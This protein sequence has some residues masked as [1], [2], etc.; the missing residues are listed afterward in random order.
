[1]KKITL[2]DAERFVHAGYQYVEG[3][4][5]CGSLAVLVQRELFDRDVTV[6]PAS[7]RSAGRLG[8]RRDILRIQPETSYAVETPETGD[9]VLYWNTEGSEKR[10]HVGTVFLRDGEVWVLH[11]VDEERGVM[12][13]RDADLRG[14]GLV[15]D[16]FYRWKT[17]TYAL[18]LGKH[19]LLAQPTET[20]YVSA[21]RTLAETLA[22][23]G[24]TGTGWVVTIEG[25]EVPPAMW[26]RTRVKE[27][28]R[29]LARSVAR[30]QVL[31]LV[32]MLVLT[33]FTFGIAGYGGA[34]AGAFGGGFA[35]FAAAAVVFVGGSI[36]INKFLGPKMGSMD[37]GGENVPPTYSLS[38]GRNAGRQWQ[39][40]SLVLGQTKA[41]PD[42]A[43]QPYTWME[44]DDQYL[45][46]TLHAGI[47]CGSVADLRN[48][49]TL[50]STYESVTVRRYGFP[51]GDSD[52]LP[53]LPTSV[54]TVPGGQLD[55]PNN[56]PGPYRY[57]T[58][59]ITTVRLEIDIQ[60]TLSALSSKGKQQTAV[61][62]I[63]IAY[64]PVG[65]NT[66]LPFNEGSIT[67]SNL[68]QKP[69]RR[70]FA[71]DVPEGQYQIRVRKLTPD[72][73]DDNLKNH[74]LEWTVLRSFQP[75][76]AD[77]G[78]QPRVELKIKATGQISGALD[79][80]NWIA[81]A[82]P[83]PIWD[84]SSW[85]TATTP[86]A[87]GLSNPGAQI[88]RLLR[89]IYRSS[90]G[91]LIAGAGLPDRRIDIESLKAFMV[92]C[93]TMGFRYDAM[94]QEALSLNDLLQSIAYAGLGTMSDHSGRIGVVYAAESQ[95]TEGVVNMVAMKAKSFEITYTLA[96]TADEYQLEFFDR[97]SDW[98]W[99]S[100]R[101]RAPGVTTP[102]FSSS[103]N[104]RGVTTRDHAAVLARFSQG[105][106]LYGRKTISWDMDLEHVRYRRGAIVAL[107][108]DLTQW[109]YGGACRAITPGIGSFTVVV[110]EPIPTEVTAVRT[111][112]LNVPG[113]ASMRVFPV[114][115]VSSNGRVITVGQAWPAS[116]ALPGTDGLAAHDYRWIYDIKASPGYRVRILSIEPDSDLKGAR[117]T[118]TPDSPEFWNYVINGEYIPPPN[119]SLLTREQ[120]VVSNLQVERTRV[121]VGDAWEHR[122]NATWDVRGQYSSAQVWSAVLGA[123]LE[124]VEGGSV[125][126]GTSLSWRVPPDQAWIIE[127]RPFDE[128]GRPGVKAVFT[129]V[130]PS[131]TVGAVQNLTVFPDSTGMMAMWKAPEADWI[132]TKLRLGV[133]WEL[134]QQV[135]NG[136]ADRYNLG[137]LP[138]DDHIL[139]A[140]HVNTADDESPPVGFPFTVLAPLQPIITASPE[141]NEAR[142]TWTECRTTQPLRAYEVRIGDLYAEALLVATTTAPG[143]VHTPPRAGTHM[144]WVTAIDVAE[145]AGPPGYIAIT[146][147]PGITEGI[148]E[149]QQGLEDAYAGIIANKADIDAINAQ[150]ADITGAPEWDV[151]DTYA[152]DQIVKHSGG[153]YRSKIDGNIG[154]E[155]SGATDEFWEKI[156]D[157]DSIGEAVAAHAIQL[158]DHETRIVNNEGELEAQSSRI[159][160]IA[161]SVTSSGA[162]GII[163][164]PELAQG[165]N[166]WA[167]TTGLVAYAADAAGVPAGS[168]AAQLVSAAAQTSG[169]R[170]NGRLL[171]GAVNTAGDVVRVTPGERI[172][173]A[174]WVRLT[175][176]AAGGTSLVAR[177]GTTDNPT[178]QVVLAT[179]AG[180]GWQQLT[181]TFV[182][183]AGASFVRLGMR[184]S[185]TGAE[186][187]AWY[188][189]MQAI[190]RGA[191]TVAVNAAVEEATSALASSIQAEA[192][193]RQTVVANITSAS[194]NNLITNPTFDPAGWRDAGGGGMAVDYFA[195][196]AAGVPAAAPSARVMRLTKTAAAAAWSGREL[197]FGTGAATLAE[198]RPN[199]VVDFSVSVWAPNGTPANSVLLQVFAVDAANAVIAGSPVYRFYVPATGGWQVLSGALT[200]PAGAVAFAGHFVL[201]ESAP[202]S[203]VMWVAEPDVRKRSASALNLGAS[204]QATSTALAT[205]DGKVAASYTLTV[206]AGNRVAGFRAG[207]DGVTSDFVVLADKFAWS[208]ESLGQV[209]YGLVLGLINGV[210]SFGFSG[211]M[212]LDGVLQ[213]RMIGADQI[214]AVHIRTDEI[215][216]R[217]LKAG[218]VLAD[219]LGVGVSGNMLPN[220]KLVTT[221]GWSA[222]PSAGVLAMLNPTNYLGTAYNPQGENILT[223]YEPASTGAQGTN[224]WSY[225]IS[226]WVG[227]EALQRYG[228]SAYV[229]SHRAVCQIYIEFVDNGGQ[230]VGSSDP[231]NGQGTNDEQGGGGKYLTWFKRIYGFA[232]APAN[233]ASARLILRKSGNKYGNADSWLMATL[234]FLGRATPYQVL[235][236]DYSPS[237]VGTLID[238]SG[239]R[240]TSLGAISPDMGLVVKGRLVSNSAVPGSMTVDLD[241][242]SISMSRNGRRVEINPG[243]F[244]F[245]PEGYWDPKLFY[246]TASD[247]MVL[248]GTF[249]ADSINAVNTLNIAGQAVTTMRNRRGGN[250]GPIY[251]G[252]VFGN[253][254][255]L[256]TESAELKSGGNGVI[257]FVEYES[258]MTAGFVQSPG[259]RIVNLNT[260]VIVRAWHHSGYDSAGYPAP[261]DALQPLPPGQVLTFVDYSPIIG[262]NNYAFQTVH[263]KTW[264]THS[265]Y[266]LNILASHR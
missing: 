33:Y 60:G 95:P 69:V 107:S 104:V 112:G 155:P 116:A 220:S 49:N 139:W 256:M 36:L 85:Q 149:L 8:Q 165:V 238:A 163:A 119:N 215:E 249:T 93:T 71:Q 161:A 246:D 63:E 178:T 12:L 192:T 255:T 159:D 132:A 176:A 198:G 50:L 89:G 148:E 201:N 216:A 223:L 229:G 182:A 239:I 51:T 96:T 257:L 263:Y 25:R 18:E 214:R 124:L 22:E 15:R 227:V 187:L 209:K 193:A 98:S 141:I 123:P 156:G 179:Y 118:A 59:S 68:G 169:E 24:V 204:V 102:Q 16:A 235:P 80:I 157:Y 262:T 264:V 87:A 75:D 79:E 251:G 42:L 1:M 245:G 244:W 26:S 21:G 145:N 219:K 173:V 232:T 55:A 138:A 212:Y 31:A 84:G 73:T 183:P 188:A 228:V 240:T 2:A 137:W 28:M 218:S 230:W 211:N 175:G 185:L 258:T 181:G 121:R 103:E 191:A 41:I 224:V 82:A 120:P 252:D 172:D 195:R 9:A 200:L 34:V 5:D 144:Y 142:L 202:T 14:T 64:Q 7:E 35:G 99:Q 54:D 106:S 19:P 105:Q 135:F 40:L 70:T 217:H 265:K 43:N 72:P 168:P 111:L 127:V 91:K 65:T 4:F 164:D 38:G 259:Y 250:G 46:T 48:G 6:P 100:V 208:Y 3:E 147:L 153:L 199:E 140:A 231:W 61:A 236:T 253:W 110:D 174:I 213:A 101:V 27:G 167:P 88:L 158:S 83:M 129:F 160:L 206:T 37:V 113:E 117:I 66:W 45:A 143:I 136:K 266:N 58:S 241:N 44:G 90:D 131:V 53:A 254:T 78:G 32:A 115:N 74:S 154:H 197:R 62:V 109:G 190:R 133:T 86:G 186:G 11:L 77:Y 196:G 260:G 207:T 150:I 162:E 134:G 52:T 248:K 56:A 189:G 30:K 247:T 242:K 151:A 67:L 180:S 23:H 203:Q 226:D 166:S 237:G 13:Q 57:A 194:S 29:V 152:E 177:H 76:R 261:P 146:T 92:R 205:L 20:R 81:T 128:L 130:D 221:V 47:N 10:W 94:I 225:W 125:V 234:P 108:H 97:D 114:T 126:L 243:G 17:P 122:L 233:A 170:Y 184:R 210:A 171:R 39:P 222:A